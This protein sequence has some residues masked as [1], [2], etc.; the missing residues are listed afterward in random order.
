[1][2][3]VHQ[4]SR[5]VKKW[6]VIRSEQWNHRAKM[7]RLI[8]I[9]FLTAIPT[10]FVILALSFA[11]M[12]LAPGG[13]FDRERP[14]DPAALETLR[15]VYNLDAPLWRQFLDYLAALARVDL[16]PSLAWREYSVA[17]LFAQALPVSAA[18]GVGALVIALP[19]G[20]AA[21]VLAAA[22]AG[23]ALEYVILVVASIG[24]TRRVSFSGRS[25]N[26]SSAFGSNGCPLAARATCDTTRCR[27][28]CSRRR[29]SRRL[30]G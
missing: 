27:S 26:L 21:G 8:F 15:R 9:R 2:G 1:L 16:G 19:L 6:S 11:L 14:L 23:S 22:R 17:E 4:Q 29:R 18:L 28:R 10:L 25:C 7:R 13:P 5:L 24:I 12:R 3:F 30:R 20:A